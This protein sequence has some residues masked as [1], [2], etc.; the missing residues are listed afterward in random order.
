LE[1]D[2]NTARCVAHHHRHRF[3]ERD[4]FADWRSYIGAK[5]RTAERNVYDL[6]VACLAGWKDELMQSMVAEQARTRAR[7]CRF[8]FA[9]FHEVG[10][11]LSE[12]VALCLG[13]AKPDAQAKAVT[14]HDLAFE[15]AEAVD[16]KD[17]LR[18]YG[19]GARGF[20]AGPVGRQIADDTLLFP[21]AL[22]KEDLSLDADA[23]ALA[24]TPL[25]TGKT[26]PA[27][28]SI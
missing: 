25:A 23:C 24:S 1:G 20:E 17:S 6:T 16:I 8:Y 7:P 12:A 14:S 9:A 15:T 2:G 10:D 4:R 21:L 18:S 22:G 5:R 28:V 27:L 3:A 26:E 19:G 13:E 11:H